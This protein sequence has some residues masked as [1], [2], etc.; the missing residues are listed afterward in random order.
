MEFNLPRLP[1]L[2]LSKLQALLLLGGAFVLGPLLW[3]AV[4]YRLVLDSSPEAPPSSILAVSLVRHDDAFLKSEGW[5]RFLASASLGANGAFKGLALSKRPTTLFADDSPEESR[6][7]LIVDESGAWHVPRLRLVERSI[8]AVGFITID[9]HRQ[10]ITVSFKENRLEMRVGRAY[11]G[12]LHEPKTFQSGLRLIHPIKE[13]IAHIEKPSGVVWNGIPQAFPVEMQR[14]QALAEPWTWPGKIEMTV[15]GSST[16]ES[17]QPFVLLYQPPVGQTALKEEIDAFAKNLLSEAF[18]Q[19][20]KVSMP[21][22][23]VMTEFRHDPN[24][25]KKEAIENR[26]GT[27]L[28][29]TIP[30]KTQKIMVFLADVGDVWLSNDLGLIQSA[31][32]DNVGAVTST[33]TCEKGGVGGFASFAGPLVS[34]LGQFKKIDLSLQNLETG[35]FTVCGYY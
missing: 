26:F 14:F 9:N 34:N 18:P 7:G 15:S 22:D 23:S 29:F 6:W 8:A 30:G 12:I 17:L 10:P 33:Q 31:L 2:T 11:R 13:Q 3:I 27:L 4:H 25:V 16:D 35:L 24:S 19:A 28:R 5:E 20:V 1:K 21:D 32:L